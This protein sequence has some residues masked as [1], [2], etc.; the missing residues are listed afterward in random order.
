[1]EKKRPNNIAN[2]W[3][4]LIKC[5]IH[6]LFGCSSRISNDPWHY[7]WVPWEQA[8]KQVIGY[9]KGCSVGRFS[10]E[11][12]KHGCSNNHWYHEGS[13]DHGLQLSLVCSP[14]AGK[15]DY[16]PGQ[17]QTGCSKVTTEIYRSQNWTGLA[18][19]RR[20]LQMHQYWPAPTWQSTGSFSVPAPL[21]HTCDHLNSRDYVPVLLARRRS[22]ACC[23][24]LSVRKRADEILLSSFQYA[25]SE[26]TIVTKPVK[27]KI[28]H[29]AIRLFYI[30]YTDEISQVNWGNYERKGIKT[31]IC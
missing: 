13:K 4:C 8:R 16:L 21:P 29:W 20:S 22:I 5:H 11:H 1:M 12:I 15:N 24:S 25:H 27:R 26:L 9:H 31:D 28:L 3:T 23:R 17:R 30:K 7:E 19:R 6:R 14:A 18:D 10:V 2:R